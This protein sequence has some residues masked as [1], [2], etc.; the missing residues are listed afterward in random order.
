MV[1]L[2]CACVLSLGQGIDAPIG[3]SKPKPSADLE[4]LSSTKV[5]T[6]VAGIFQDPLRCDSSGNLY[7][8]AYSEEGRPIK[9]LDRKGRRL[10]V[11]SQTYIS[12]VHVNN[13]RY[14]SIRSDDT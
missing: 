6:E 14:F 13:R 12:D 3:K 4:R 5:P 2:P 11:F 7:F 1:W 9:K 10:A 8:Y